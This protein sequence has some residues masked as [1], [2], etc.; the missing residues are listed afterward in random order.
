[1]SATATAPM[2]ERKLE[3][4]PSRPNVNYEQIAKLAYL[5]W[6]QRGCPN[7]SPELDWLEAERQLH[8]ASSKH[9]SR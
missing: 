9:V 1:M 6:E 2:T 7:G 3:E 8:K 5:F 4:T